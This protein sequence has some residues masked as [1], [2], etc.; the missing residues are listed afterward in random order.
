MGPDRNASIALILFLA[1]SIIVS[2]ASLGSS[3]LFIYR[4]EVPL[5]SSGSAWDALQLLKNNG[6]AELD[7]FKRFPLLLPASLLPQELFDSL[8]FPALAFLCLAVSFFVWRRE[9]D[10]RELPAS[11]RDLLAFALAFI[12]LVNPI[13]LQ[14]FPSLFPMLDYALFPLF[15]MLLRDGIARP[16]NRS[17]FLSSLL[18]SFMVLMVVHA[19]L[20]VII[21]LA[22]MIPLVLRERPQPRRLASSAALFALVFLSATA[23]ATLPYFQLYSS[24]GTP[25]EV[26]PASA[27]LL[28]TFSSVAALPGPMLMDFR[29]FWWP[30]VPY[31]Y[32]FGD[33]FLLV[34]A[35]LLSALLLFGLYERS[36]LSAAALLG[37]GVLFFLAKGSQ[38][39]L[40]GLYGF[41][42]TSLP[43]GW[44]IRVPGKFLH[45]IPFFYVALLSRLG[46]SVA[47]RRASLLAPMLALFMLAFSAYAWPFFT[48]DAGGVLKKTGI[49]ARIDDAAGMNEVFGDPAPSLLYHGRPEMQ[50]L[51]ADGDYGGPF[52]SREFDAYAAN[53]DWSGAA[54]GGTLGYQYLLL[55]DSERAGA[56]RSL[57]TAY[58]GK[59]FSLL[60]LKD[61]GTVFSAPSGSTLCYC[62]YDT[63]RSIIRSPPE[64]GIPEALLFPM[65]RRGFQDSMLASA[66]TVIFD[67]VAPPFPSVSPASSGGFGAQPYD[68]PPDR[69]WSARELW[70]WEDDPSPEPDLNLGFA[71]TSSEPFLSRI[72]DSGAIALADL[73]FTASRA[74]PSGEGSY[75]FAVTGEDDGPASVISAA[76]PRSDSGQ[77]NVTLALTPSGVRNLS[78]YIVSRD[79]SGKIVSSGR[80][81]ISESSPIAEGAAYFIPSSAV[82]T[83]LYI[84]AYPDDDS[85]SL[86]IDDFSASLLEYSASG[87][88]VSSGFRVPESG[89]FEVYVH[90]LRSGKGGEVG[91]SVD[92]SPESVVDTK[93]PRD[94]FFWALAYSGPLEKGAHTLTAEQKGGVNAVNAVYAVPAGQQPWQLGGKRIIYRLTS[95]DFSGPG[96]EAA[97]DSGSSTFSALEV[98]GNVS[99]SISVLAPGYYDVS[100]SLSGNAT[101]LVDGTPAGPDVYLGRG[102]HAVT[103]APLGGRVMLDQVTLEKPASAP[104]YGAEIT[105]VERNG[106]SSYSVAVNSTG[107]FLLQFGGGYSRF[108]T[109]SAGGD[110]YYPESSYG[111][112]NLY[113]INGSGI[114]AISVEYVPQKTAYFGMF[115]AAAGIL[116][117]GAVAW[118]YDR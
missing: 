31:S 1:L 18:A 44:L 40:S 103:V 13:S 21:S 46:L 30:Y 5:L 47:G 20:Y 79:A 27:S 50:L 89:D 110:T 91:L 78:A 97:A 58:D 54:I 99:S 85:A 2:W 109:A 105:G 26:P 8:K 11:R 108:W 10:G 101:V 83:M 94:R 60:R 29:S 65:A 98:R 48:G 90:L 67:S 25:L 75:S 112:A 7:T 45:L 3:G 49:S 17:V 87:E 42:N 53:G 116:L 68:V 102:V 52:L 4:D 32:P 104:A 66:G 61:G 51:K 12:Y 80:L 57:P 35:V 107:P 38:E 88:K 39:P 55:P 114:S 115:I 77:Y 76:L 73:D 100:Y 70:D 33:A 6:M 84:Y 82:A 81:K 34:P 71:L 14:L 59:E 9:L 41:L 63:A 96:S 117:G 28:G 43:L 36:G 92:G 72:G 86:S 24:G 64:G 16:S 19:L 22:L 95:D 74:Q 93:D 113:Y 106:P 37:L 56:A 15:F 118:R 69:N 23:F 62:S 111:A